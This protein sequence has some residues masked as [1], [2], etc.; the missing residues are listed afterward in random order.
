MHR[1]E[2]VAWLA[3]AMALLPVAARAQ[4][5]GKVYRIGVF[6]SDNPIMGP[7]YAALLD[8]LRRLGFIDG[9]NLVVSQRTTGQTPA[10]LASDVAEMVRAKVDVIFAGVQP[11]L[12][13]A[14]G[15]GIPIVVA[16][17][18]FDPIAHGY[19]KSLSRPEVTSPAWF[20]DRP[21]WPRSRSSC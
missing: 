21:N 14:A 19:V 4:Q 17:I 18:N 20:C 8:E 15:T 7:A 13:A 1:R 9:Q 16:A 12:Q 11:A 5:A 3:S 10:G 2:F 6:S